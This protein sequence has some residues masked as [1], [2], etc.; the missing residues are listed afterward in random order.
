MGPMVS[1]KFT[2]QKFKKWDP[3]TEVGVGKW[4]QFGD[5]PYLKFNLTPLSKM[6]YLC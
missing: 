2:L 6:V 3:K 1:V 4:L 5:G